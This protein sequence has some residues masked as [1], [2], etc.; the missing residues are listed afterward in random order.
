LEKVKESKEFT[1]FK[2]SSGRYAVKDD[3]KKWVNGDKK[4]EILTKEGLLKPMKK[5][6]VEEAPAAEAAPT[7]TPQ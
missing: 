5:K 7:E 4:V 1:I 3:K 6:K 2:K